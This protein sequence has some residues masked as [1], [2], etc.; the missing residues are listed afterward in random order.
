MILQ[1]GLVFLGVVI[2]MLFGTPIPVAF[3]AGAIV[4]VLLAGLD[5]AWVGSQA[6]NL[7]Q[8]FVF[9]AF[10]L[11]VLL[12]TVVNLSG[13]AFRLC[14]W[15]V[16][17]FGRIKGGLGVA[18]I[19]TNGVFAAMS[20]SSLSALA[21]IGRA[22]L[23]NLEERGYSK[24]YAISLLIPSATL[25]LQI[26][27]SGG[28][29]IF[30]FM[31]GLPISLCFLSSLIPGVVLLILLCIVHLIMCRN[32]T[33]IEVPPK[34]DLKSD[35]KQIWGASKKAILALLIPVICLGGI[36]AGFYTPTEAAGAGAI[37][38]I[39]VGW[40]F[41]RTLGPKL[42]GKSLLDTG[43]ITSS[44]I[45]VIFFFTVISKVLIL[46]QVSEAILNLLLAISSNLYVQIFM[47]NFLMFI[48]GCLIDDASV[49]MISAV[50]LLPVAKSLG[51][52][53]YHMAAMVSVTHAIGLITPPVAALLYLGGHIADLP[54]NKYIG[55]T[56]R[57]TLFAMV[58]TALITM[59]VPSFST[60]LPYLFSGGRG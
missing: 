13:V 54:L 37:Y 11:Y 30:G 22:L 17:L 35:A 43:I 58:P 25:A 28:M 10:P 46:T 19:C 21:G 14:D 39:L 53:P 18:A 2:I 23:P 27:P 51:I 31:G 41:Y 48:L 40:I 1:V 60:F 59:Y 3:C 8:S 36:Y 52:D 12:G 24:E 44:I 50:I 20:G 7:V 26:P 16:A 33:N 47:L 6:F 5:L 42:L 45:I 49:T 55:T 34:L 56:F 57:F 15:F 9:L 32:M 38:A 4:M 29:I